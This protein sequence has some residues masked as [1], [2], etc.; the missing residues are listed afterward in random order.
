M[1]KRTALEVRISHD[2]IHETLAAFRALPKDASN[3]LRDAAIE[4][5]RILAGEAKTSG[6]D[7]GGQAAAVAATVRAARDRVPVVVAGGLKKLGRNKKPAY[8]LL[9]GSEFGATEYTQYQPHLGR[10]SYW[11]FRTIEDNQQRIMEEWQEA[12]D[13]IVRKFGGI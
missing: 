10:G 13:A 2:G 6:R 3:E 1:A 4:L 12:A 11:F 7:E 8:K 5:S 9:F